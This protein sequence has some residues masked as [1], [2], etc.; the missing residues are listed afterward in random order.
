[1]TLKIPSRQERCSDDASAKCRKARDHMEI[2][3][4]LPD[5]L[6]QFPDPAPG[7]CQCLFLR[8]RHVDRALQMGRPVLLSICPAGRAEVTSDCHE[9]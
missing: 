6:L 5:F 3:L 9:A 7:L 2:E 4:L 1:M 8:C